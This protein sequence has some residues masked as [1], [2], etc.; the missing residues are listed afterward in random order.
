MVVDSLSLL[1]SGV[2]CKDDDIGFLEIIGSVALIW[3][4][5]ESFTVGVARLIGL[6]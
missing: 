2:G 6:G 3:P 5:F 4:G 1:A